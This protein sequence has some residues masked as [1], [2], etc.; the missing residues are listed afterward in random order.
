MKFR[1]ELKDV[2]RI[3][4]KVGSNV[5]TRSDGSYDL[6]RLRILVEDICELRQAGVQVLLVSSGAV[7]I[8]RVL[9]DPNLFKEDKIEAQ[10]AASSLG[11]PKLM[12]KYC[13]LFEENNSLCSQVLLTHEDFKCPERHS[14]AKKTVEVLLENKVTPILNENDTISFVEIT[15]GD[16]DQLAALV[17]GLIEADLLLLITSAEG[18]F[19]KDPEQEG[20]R[21]FKR[22]EYGQD[23]TR[24]ETK[25]LSANGRGGMKSKLEAVKKATEA[26]IPAI[27]SSKDN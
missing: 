14:N 22:V 3:V 11:Q 20:A 16:N 4:I 9:L 21:L 27:I 24:I 12:Q 8:G 26:G 10:Q 18:L 7:N 1:D 13:G 19:D 15:F 25:V 23:L 17:A 5:V 6:R 2:K